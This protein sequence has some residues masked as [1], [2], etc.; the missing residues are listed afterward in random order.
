MCRSDTVAPG[1]F[2]KAK[3]LDRRSSPAITPVPEQLIKL[4]LP[5]VALKFIRITPL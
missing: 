3:S 5:S 4:P 2:P 1:T